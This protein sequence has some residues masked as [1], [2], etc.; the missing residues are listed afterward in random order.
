MDMHHTSLLRTI[1]TAYIHVGALCI[2]RDERV[3]CRWLYKRR[4]WLWLGPSKGWKL[5]I[6]GALHRW[7]VR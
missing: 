6:L 5:F 1:N 2:V 3:A 7:L 4:L